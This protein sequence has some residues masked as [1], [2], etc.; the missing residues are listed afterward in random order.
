[1]KKFVPYD[2]FGKACSPKGKP[3]AETMQENPETKFA[4]DPPRPCSD[5]PCPPYWQKTC[6]QR[7]LASGMMEA[8]EADGCGNTRWVRIAETVVWTDTGQEEC[9]LAINIFKKEQTNQCGE[10]RWVETGVLCCTPTWVNSDCGTAN[11]NNCDQSKVRVPQEDGCGNTRMY[12]TG[13]LVAWSDNGSRR[14]LDGNYQK[15]EANQCAATRWV[16]L[17]PVTWVDSG[18]TRCAGA[19]IEKE[20][21]DSC[22][23]TRWVATGAVLTW[24]DTTTVSCAGGIYSV[25]QV[26]ECGTTRMQDRG[27]VTWLNTGIQR[28]SA[29]DMVE[30]EQVNQC[31]TLRW[32]ETGATCT[33]TLPPPTFAQEFGCHTKTANHH[34]AAAGEALRFHP[35]GRWT[36]TK[37]TEYNAEYM[38]GMWITDSPSD[39]GLYECRIEGTKTSYV[40]ETGGIDCL[41]FVETIEP[42]DTGWLPLSS[43]VE[44]TVNIVAMATIMCDQDASETLAFTAS[45]REILTPVNLITGSG[46]ICAEATAIAGT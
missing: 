22:G 46:S 1:M 20:Q 44:A 25:Q 24:T 36:V 26:N 38:E 21:V 12:D 40:N 28:C 34:N 23:T 4:P 5:T 41:G 11:C 9:D 27:P 31:G 32:I 8:E 3:L 17:G 33:V 19:V 13:V 29:T 35:D 45:I 15:Q 30:K 42:F 39:P 6:A 14:C 2:L 43:I 10:I 37:G 16:T 18:A 7:C